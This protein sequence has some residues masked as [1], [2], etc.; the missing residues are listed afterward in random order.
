MLNILYC[1]MHVLQVLMKLCLNLL[2]SIADS[3]TVTLPMLNF[4]ETGH[5]VLRQMPWIFVNDEHKVIVIYFNSLLILL[6]SLVK[7]QESLLATEHAMRKY[8]KPTRDKINFKQIELV[9]GNPGM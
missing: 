8:F 7:D 3:D 9:Y 6:C 1:L 4:I 5:L 2:E